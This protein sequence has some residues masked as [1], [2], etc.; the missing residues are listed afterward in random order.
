MLQLCGSDNVY[1]CMVQCLSK[2]DHSIHF[3]DITEAPWCSPHWT[4]LVLLHFMPQLLLWRLTPRSVFWSWVY[5]DHRWLLASRG[6][7][8]AVHSRTLCGVALLC[9]CGLYFHGYFTVLI[10]V[11]WKL[12]S[13]NVYVPA[14]LC[15][16]QSP[17][18]VIASAFYTYFRISFQCKYKSLL[19]FL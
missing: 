3:Q 10:A 15:F 4:T 6:S 17:F 1:S 5:V 18:L 16:S 11:I 13:G 7:H 14:L 19:E 2:M 9:W 8:L 12:K